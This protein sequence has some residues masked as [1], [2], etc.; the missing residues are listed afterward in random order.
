MEQGDAG[1]G[2]YLPP[3]VFAKEIGRIER[4]EGTLNELRTKALAEGEPTGL[5]YDLVARNRCFTSGV[6][7]YGLGP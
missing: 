2:G 5:L 3:D 1:I 7:R 4:D 6:I